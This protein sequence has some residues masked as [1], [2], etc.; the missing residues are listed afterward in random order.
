MTPTMAESGRKNGAVAAMAPEQFD[1]SG[2]VQWFWSV[3]WWRLSRETFIT[4]RPLV[5]GLVSPTLHRQ[6]SWC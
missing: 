6:T 4:Q 2:L 1:L 3:V 5:L